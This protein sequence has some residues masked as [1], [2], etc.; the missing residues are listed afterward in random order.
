MFF[1]DDLKKLFWVVNSVVAVIA[2]LFPLPRPDW[3]KNFSD[4]DDHYARFLSIFCPAILE[5]RVY[6]PEM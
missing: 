6:K 5:R 4:R 1:G 2:M 3:L